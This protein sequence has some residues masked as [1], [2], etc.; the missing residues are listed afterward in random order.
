MIP[1]PTLECVQIEQVYNS[2]DIYAMKQHTLKYFASCDGPN[3]AADCLDFSG[4]SYSFSQ[5]KMN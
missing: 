4:Y 1:Y 2:V 3:P 5:L